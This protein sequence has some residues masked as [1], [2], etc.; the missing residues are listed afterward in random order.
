M[1]NEKRILIEIGPGIGD[2]IVITPILS[3]LKEM[4]P[5]CI[6]SILTAK[7]SAPIIERLSCVDHIY[8]LERHKFLGQ[9]RPLIHLWKYDFIIFTNYQ[10]ALAIGSWLL[11]IPHRAG[12]C[13]KKYWNFPFFNCKFPYDI[14]I[15][16]SQLQIFQKRIS[17]A[18]QIE[19]PVTKD[20]LVSLP[21]PKEEATLKNKLLLEHFV[22]NQPYAVI[23]PFG[24]S[25]LNLPKPL[26][27]KVVEYLTNIYHLTCILIDGKQHDFSDLIDNNLTKKKIINLCG[28]TSLMEIVSLLQ[29]A[30][31]TVST[32]S[33]P[34]HISCACKTPTVDIFTNGIPERW[35]VS[36]YCYP[37]CIHAD[38]SPCQIKKE[39]CTHKKC[40]Y[41]ITPKMVFD[42]ID[43]VM[44][45]F[46]KTH[47][48]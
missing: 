38:C 24:N 23:S 10:P 32:D 21:S 45:Q 41:D 26:I 8:Y 35:A 11:R 14:I 22:L 33:G 25:S 4:Y 20:F 19:I 37:V 43:V 17:Q 46:N 1:L 9:I 44:K 39:N 18:L 36:E 7:K 30:T 42:Q 16:T 3:K 5:A 40:I 15:R 6:I 28:K 29:H 47:A 13:K 48:S 12:I 27:K 34:V 2:L 31:I